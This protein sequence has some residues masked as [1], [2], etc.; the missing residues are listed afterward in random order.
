MVSW[1]FAATASIVAFSALMESA[2]GLEFSR[3]SRLQYE[4]TA[5]EMVDV[6]ELEFVALVNPTGRMK[7]RPSNYYVKFYHWDGKE[8]IRYRGKSMPFLPFTDDTDITNPS[9]DEADE[10]SW[11]NLP[12][13][14]TDDLIKCE[15]KRIW[16]LIP[17][18]GPL[19]YIQ[20]LLPHTKEGSTAYVNLTDV[21]ATDDGLVE[22][23]LLDKKNM[24]TGTALKLRFFPKE[25]YV[26][27]TLGGK[28][29]VGDI[30]ADFFF[31]FF[32]FSF[33]LGASGL[34]SS[35]DMI[36]QPKLPAD[37]NLETFPLL[38]GKVNVPKDDQQSN[39]N[40]TPLQKL[41]LRF[42][43][44][45][46]DTPKNNPVGDR[47]TLRNH[48][49]VKNLLSYV[50][51][52]PEGRWR[53][54]LSDESMS[55]VFFS[56]FGAFYIEKSDNQ[57]LEKYGSKHHYIADFSEFNNDVVTYKTGLKSLGCK[58][59]FDHKGNITMIEDDDPSRTLY[60]PGGNPVEW[61]M[62]KLKARSAA[63]I[64]VS[65]E[66][67]MNYHLF[68]GNIPASAMR[69]FLSPDHLVRLAFTPHFFKTHRTAVNSELT[70][71]KEGTTIARG[72]PFAYDGENSE[73]KGYIDI[74]H[75]VW[76]KG[77]F[78]TYED[79]LEQKGIK[80]CPYHVGAEDGLMLRDIL[81]TYV[82]DLFDEFYLTDEEFQED[83][84]I[85]DM[86][87]ELVKNMTGIPEEFSL[88]NLKF[89]FGEILFRVTGMHQFIGNAAAYALEPFMINFKM[90]NDTQAVNGNWETMHTV[91]VITGRTQPN[92]YP[93]LSNDWSRLLPCR[94]SRAFA[95]LRANLTNLGETI[96][97]RNENRRF[98]S[99]DFHP[100]VTAI[101]ILS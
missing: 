7:R 31:R 95:S 5:E 78:I 15:I 26:A 89:V 101:S 51:E 85:K 77:K 22:V 29:D 86:Y 49:R 59:F 81:M 20:S 54:P 91:S 3:R 79:E 56:S 41:L 12:F 39:Q 67:L 14:I 72:V 71:V 16:K 88:A 44:I 6:T 60:Y 30:D 42:T 21:L 69:K 32:L 73:M 62:A 35:T 84:E 48:I 8:K 36:E 99:K 40:M 94:K 11:V 100:D 97:E 80:D 37:P 2:D 53:R 50:L 46:P 19:K 34:S 61:G 47:A 23:P 96:D 57:T 63:F 58:V 17:R 38:D 25:Q 74:L 82:S 92:E 1:K 55:R 98:A 45:L 52:P 83:Q 33:H 27:G 9:A 43:L 28:F 76:D 13:V 18:L 64:L 68:W 90:E 93:T 24:P 70:L 75:S 66:H 10:V 65:S 87:E 4:T